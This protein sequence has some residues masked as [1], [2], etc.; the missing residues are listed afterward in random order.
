V[1]ESNGQDVQVPWFSGL[2]LEG[3]VAGQYEMDL[4]GSQQ[5]SVDTGVAGVLAL[6][7]LAPITIF[8]GANNSGKSRLMRELFG[9]SEAVKCLRMGPNSMEFNMNIGALLEKSFYQVNKFSP[10]DESGFEKII[11]GTEALLA[12]FRH[13]HGGA[14]NSWIGINGVSLLDTLNEY[15]NLYLRGVSERLSN[16]FGIGGRF[17]DSHEEKQEKLL[18]AA[19]VRG[20]LSDWSERYEYIRKS[21]LARHMHDFHSLRRCYVPM[22]RGMRPPLVPVRSDRQSIDASDCFEERSILDYFTSLPSWRTLNEVEAD[23]VERTQSKQAPAFS[24]KPRVF[25]GLSLYRDIQKRLLAPTYEERKSIRDYEMFLSA[26]FFQ[27][28]E[29]TLTPALHNQEGR[30]NDVVHI[31][32]GDNED[33]PIYDLGDGM[34]SLIICTY[35]IITELQR[36]SLFFLEEP[37][38]C[39]HPSLQRVLLDV[40]RVSYREKG[41]QFFLTTHSNHLLDLLEDDNLVSIFS[42][43][44]FADLAPAS[45]VSSQLDSGANAQSSKPDPC[46]RIRPSTLRD[47]QTLLELGV[48]P[49][50]TY[51]ANATIWVEGVSDCAYLRAYMEAFVHYLKIRGKD[52]GERLAQRLEQ[53]K[54]D[55]HY[56]FVEYS[57]A[58][59]T[60]FSFEERVSDNGQTET[61]VSDLCGKAIVIA[62]G[63][64]VEKGD[65]IAHF[66]DQLKER[67]ICLPCKEIEN[68]IPEELMKKQIRLD[69]TPPQRGHV[70]EDAIKNLNYAAYARSDEGLGKYLGDLGMIKYNGTTGNGGG[71]GTLPATYKSRW[72]SVEKGI[73]ALI[74]NQIDVVKNP[75]NSAESIQTD[76]LP[77]YLT[78]DLLWL[79]ILLYIHIAGCNYDKNT[80]NDLKEL[81]GHIENQVTKSELE[82]VG[83]QV[84]D[85]T[86]NVVNN[87]MAETI[88]QAET[89]PNRWPIPLDNTSSRSCLL[90]NFS[91]SAA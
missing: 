8:V 37:D 19:E 71:S 64:I 3:E 32:I 87:S 33:R 62:D 66:V 25:T 53:Y 77:D 21:Q 90:K 67:F 59:L 27:G 61:S 85:L 47:R 45:A 91:P 86:P 14:M 55:R 51:L 88:D 60:H 69:H 1:G 9:N 78:Q 5:E 15:V 52:W 36:G 49:S 70:D 17:G 34:Q 75:V 76:D 44:E 84:P 7:G 10:K 12:D 26:N 80:E 42:F 83:E 74:R 20:Y 73:P 18:V 63:D 28:R 68:L 11:A 35:P 65:R 6:D 31:K 54:E 39:M 89:I 50:A 72:R 16:R 41:H 4:S 38:L 23:K 13:W 29:V 2:C 79:C 48:R 46:F 30:N 81:Q 40:L 24:E 82:S 57:G 22:L 58:N 43:S 56:A